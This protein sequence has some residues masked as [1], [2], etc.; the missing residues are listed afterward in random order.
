MEQLRKLQHL[1]LVSKVTAELEN[2]LNIADKTLA[3]FVI[4]L[5]KDQKNV[6]AFNKVRRGPSGSW[7]GSSPGD[8]GAG[9]RGTSLALLPGCSSLPVRAALAR[10]RRPGPRRRRRCG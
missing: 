2:H 5:A 1:S 3:E 4:E 10:A 7:D 6:D 9:A 8:A